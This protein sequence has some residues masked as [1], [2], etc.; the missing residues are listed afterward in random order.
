VAKQQWVVVDPLCSSALS[1]LPLA[2]PTGVFW[3]SNRLTGVATSGE[4]LGDFLERVCF[5]KILLSDAVHEGGDC[6]LE[7]GEKKFRHL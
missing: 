5:R 7:F 2:R 4:G 3:E 6:T 1:L